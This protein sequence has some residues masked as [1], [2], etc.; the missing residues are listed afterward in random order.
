MNS[1]A[2]TTASSPGIHTRAERPAIHVAIVNYKTPE[3][4]IDCLRSLVDEIKQY[5]GSQVVVA[6]NASPDGS[7][8]TISNAI[9]SNGWSAW[10]R[11]EQMPRNGGFA[12]G[13]NAILRQGLQS[14]APP[15]YF[16]MLNSDT[17]VQPNSLRAL[18]EFME[19]HPGAGV[20]GSRM[21]DPD[22]TQQTS[23]FRFHS[24]VGELEASIAA[25]PVSKLLAR[26]RVPMPPMQATG[27]CE[28]VCGASMFLRSAMLEMTGLLDEAYFLY[29]EE[30][31]FC[32]T[33]LMKDWTCWFVAESRVV[34][35]MGQ[36]SGLTG[37]DTGTRRLSAYWFESRRYY[38]IKNHGRIY[39]VCADLA[40]MI[41]TSINQ[42]RKL[43]TGRPTGVPERFLYDLLRHSAL[44]TN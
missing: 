32:R 7:G 38:F 11:V 40:L 33:C 29:Y 24:I 34:H 10:A 25:G 21:E 20:A 37:H 39:A 42:V 8:G 14:L 15:R 35:L 30:T 28:W 27:P 22:G 41:G 1:N 9:A 12:Y 17:I 44:L 4:T 2:A 31:D 23:T 16:W 3:M 5:P 36:S 26:W 19:A 43:L 18:V 13:N 6:D